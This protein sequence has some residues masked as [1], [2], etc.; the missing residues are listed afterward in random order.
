M[1]LTD[2][3]AIERSLGEPDQFRLVFERHHAGVWR[4]LRHRLGADAADE[5]GGETF[6]RAF[7]ARAR[8]RDD[9]GTALPWLLGI[10]TNL[11]ADHRRREGRRLQAYARCGQA[12]A[13][14]LDVDGLIARLAALDEGPALAGALAALRPDDRETLLLSAVAGLT[15]TEVAEALDIPA[16]TVAS[17]LNRARALLAPM[18]EEASR[19]HV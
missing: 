14:E 3:E 9:T 4:Y 6:V 8:Y 13:D 7:A 18:L 1:P 10:A 19:G 17:R 16:G 2:A 5:L 11:A 12:P 15:H